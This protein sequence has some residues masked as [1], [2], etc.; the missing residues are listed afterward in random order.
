MQN[1]GAKKINTYKHSEKSSI[2]K[3]YAKVIIV[4]KLL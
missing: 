1:L 4:F 2:C 3:N